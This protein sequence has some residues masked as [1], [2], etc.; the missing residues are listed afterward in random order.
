MMVRVYCSFSS[1]YDNNDERKETINGNR[2]RAWETDSEK[3]I[4]E[5][6]RKEREKVEKTAWMIKIK[7]IEEL[8]V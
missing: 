4:N 2:V 5:D 1:L 6:L 7:V 8:T 3:K